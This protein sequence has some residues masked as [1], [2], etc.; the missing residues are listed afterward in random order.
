MQ[1]IFHLAGAA[2]SISLILLA[3]AIQRPRII[4]LLIAVDTFTMIQFVISGSYGAVA[5]TGV[6]L[7][8]ALLMIQSGRYQVLNRPLVFLAVAGVYVFVFGY[9]QKGELVSWQLLILAGAFAS[10]LSMFLTNQEAVKVIQLLGSLCYISFS[11]IIGAYSQLPG[12]VFCFM[13]LVVSLCYILYMRKRGFEGQVPEI[14]TI[15]REKMIRRK[16]VI[17]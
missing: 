14:T 16:K 4:L 11:M 2:T 17:A 10:M 7:A 9:T 15:V 8:Y 13:L 12:Q 3:F 5:V 6:S 1:T